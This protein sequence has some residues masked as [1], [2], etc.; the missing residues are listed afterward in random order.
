L[1]QQVKK[2]IIQKEENTQEENE[3]EELWNDTDK[4]RGLVVR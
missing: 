1:E 4:W 3:E 2:Y